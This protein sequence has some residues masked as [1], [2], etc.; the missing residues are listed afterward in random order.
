[1]GQTV[2]TEA[3]KILGPAEIPTNK[4]GFSAP[5]VK[6]FS[7]GVKRFIDLYLGGASTRNQFGHRISLACNFSERSPVGFGEPTMRRPSLSISLA[8]KLH[9]W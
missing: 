8:V 4:V 3:L 7:S 9:R 2:R 5:I 1:L 6:S